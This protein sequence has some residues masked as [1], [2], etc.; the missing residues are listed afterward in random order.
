MS[1]EKFIILTEVLGNSFRVGK[2]TLFKC[3]KC[4]HHK[5]KLSV[6]I[7]KGA[8]KCWVC[9]Y[10]GVNIYNLIKGRGTY[11]QK[12]AWRELD[13]KVE[14]NDFDSLF[15][16]EEKPK[17]QR[18]DLPKDFKTLTSNN[19]SLSALPALNYLKKRGVTKS[20]ILRWKIGYSLSGEYANRI[21][22]PSFDEYG[23]V[24]YFVARTYVDA[25]PQ[26]K[27]PPVSKNIVFNEL[28]V[29]WNEPVVIVEGAFDAIKAGNAIPIL[30]STLGEKSKLFERLISRNSKVFIA[31]DKDASKKALKLV[32]SLLQYDVNVYMV[33][34]SPYS[35]VGEMT[36]KEF[37]ERREKASFVGNDDYL[38][39]HALNL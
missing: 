29:D 23:Y 34:I 19:L 17:K 28:F 15:L 1:K 24:N 25:W 33:D 5:N 32:R 16:E 18:I 14:I 37:D 11:E 36:A 2:E 4:N 3:P 12:S 21:I 13:G 31:L 9:D 30:G 27:N 38:L 10:S 20:D 26:Y 7:Q 35:D 22:I 6:N 8:F 39:Y